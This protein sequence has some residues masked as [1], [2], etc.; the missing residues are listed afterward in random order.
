[1]SKVVKTNVLKNESGCAMPLVGS[2]LYPYLTA[3]TYYKEYL[4]KEASI[5]FRFGGAGNTNQTPPT[6]AKRVITNKPSRRCRSLIKRTSRMYSFL[7]KKRNKKG[8]CTLITLTY[9]DIYP[10]DIDSKKHLDNFIKRMK[11]Y[12][13]DFMYIWVA[14][15]QNRGAIHYHMLTP[16]FIPKHI[17]NK[18]WSDIV[19]R[20]YTQNGLE[21]LLVLP[22]VKG[23]QKGG[24]YLTKYLD[25][26]TDEIKG[27][28]YNMSGN[29]RELIK[30]VEQLIFEC[31]P[32]MLIGT[33][34]A[35]LHNEGFKPFEVI[36]DD[37]KTNK[38]Q[39]VGFWLEH[40]K[41]FREILKDNFRLKILKDPAI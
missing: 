15:K 3:Q 8:M 21:F 5:S 16:D 2:S 9:P 19:E 10:D 30:P 24:K 12:L 14:E 33:I 1:M 4:N 29:S 41:N 7:A 38:K 13:P 11:R 6:R 26:S 31:D 27:N 36:V 34:R 32:E 18:A 25:K 40:S 37:P 28:R 22:N 35:L 17:L 23:V 20:W 39:L